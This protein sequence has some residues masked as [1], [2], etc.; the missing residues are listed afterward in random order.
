MSAKG[1]ELKRVRQS[2]KANS[3]NRYYKSK[4]NTAIKKFLS[5]DKKEAKKDLPNIIKLIDQ[6]SSKGIIHKNKA[7][8][9]KS[10]LSLY[11]N[12]K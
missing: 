6:I 2:R 10:R 5:L 4:M 3:R 1:S 8:N 12:N 11:L 9:K 7:N